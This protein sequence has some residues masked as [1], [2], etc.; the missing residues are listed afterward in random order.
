MVSVD[1][2]VDYSEHELQVKRL[3]KEVHNLLLKSDWKAAASMID[4]TVVELRLMRTAV[5]SQ[6]KQ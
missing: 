1:S 4:M 2:A 5:K 3:M 6:I